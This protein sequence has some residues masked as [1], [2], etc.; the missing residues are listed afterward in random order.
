M[1][2]RLRFVAMVTPVRSPVQAG[3]KARSKGRGSVVS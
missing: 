2:C 3:S 1:G